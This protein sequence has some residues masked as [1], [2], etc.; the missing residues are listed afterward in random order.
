MNLFAKQAYRFRKQIYGYQR[1]LWG[2][3]R[4]K[5]EVWD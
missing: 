1:G 3:G 4:N 2:R 5:L